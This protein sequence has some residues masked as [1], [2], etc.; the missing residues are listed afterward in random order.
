MFPGRRHDGAGMIND[1]I[2]QPIARKYRY[3]RSL[4]CLLQYLR[5][6]RCRLR[7]WENNCVDSV[8][9]IVCEPESILL[10][11]PAILP[12]LRKLQDRI[13]C[14]GEWDRKFEGRDAVR[15]SEFLDLNAT[16]SGSMQNSC[17]QR[18]GSSTARPTY[19]SRKTI[20]HQ[21]IEHSFS[22]LARKIHW[23]CPQKDP[24]THPNARTMVAQVP[25]VR[26]ACWGM[27]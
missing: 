11:G 7:F 19:L 1:C 22:S 18:Q 23:S 12:A 9:A 5:Q 2:G 3:G 13:E 27:K 14:L 8:V 17:V 25:N 15:I 21:R 20:D 24:S 26:Y 16:V 10:Y 4:C 6:K